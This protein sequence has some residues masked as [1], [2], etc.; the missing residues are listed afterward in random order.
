MPRIFFV[1]FLLGMI[2]ASCATDP[3]AS[4]GAASDTTRQALETLRGENSALIARQQDLETTLAEHERQVQATTRLIHKILDDLSALAVRKDLVRSMG[5]NPPAQLAADFPETEQAIRAAETAFTR[6]LSLIE[7]NLEDSQEQIDRVRNGERI[8]PETV[9]QLTTTVSDLKEQLQQQ[10]STQTALQAATDSLRESLAER[11]AVIRRTREVND[12]LER[13]LR[14]ARRAYVA[15]GTADALED[16]KI[17]DRRFLR[18]PE[19]QRFRAEDF[20]TVSAT[21]ASI[22]FPENA[23]EAQILSLHRK[24]PDLYTIESD[25][26]LIHDPAAFWAL[27]RFLILEIDP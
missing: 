27:S 14:T 25:R 5:V 6:H 8:E 1:L 12:S 19:I 15:I 18:D 20:D 22:S 9:A 7:S 10:D 2:A 13:R 17:I 4:D 3:A 11:D 23:Q 16:R 21:T 26:L 24:I